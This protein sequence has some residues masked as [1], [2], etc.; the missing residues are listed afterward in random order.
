[1]QTVAPAP[2]P[3]SGGRNG[4]GGGDLFGGF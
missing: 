1:P 4:S 3:P 2:Q